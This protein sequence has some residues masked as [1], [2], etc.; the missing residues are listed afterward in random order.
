MSAPHLTVDPGTEKPESDGSEVTTRVLARR[1]G[2]SRLFL[3]SVAVILGLTSAVGFLSRGGMERGLESSASAALEAA[4]QTGITLSFEGRIVTAQVPTGRDADTVRQV[5]AGVEGISSVQVEKVF[6]SAKEAKACENVQTK[7]D[8]ATKQQRIPFSGTSTRPT[9]AGEQ[10][11]RDVAQL[12]RA[13]GAVNVIVGGHSDSATRGG[14]TISLER[15]RSMIA[16]LQKQ[17]IAANRMQPRGYGD[18][19]PVDRGDGPASR[20]ANQRGSIAVAVS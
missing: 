8:R 4:G 16:L 1:P 6:R 17:G 2:G 9:P 19:F 11:L 7:I 3:A 20:A 14:P 13:C 15:A 18:Q 5:L 12:L 10:M